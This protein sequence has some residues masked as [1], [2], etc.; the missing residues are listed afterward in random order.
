MA[1][2]QYNKDKLAKKLTLD[3]KKAQSN[4]SFSTQD[5]SKDKILPVTFQ[6]KWDNFWYHYK[7]HMLAAAFVVVLILSLIV[8]LVSRVKFDSTLT[9]LCEYDFQTSYDNFNMNIDEVLP[10]Y[11]EDG[12]SSLGINSILIADETNP[13]V[14]HSGEILMASQARI[15][16]TLTDG[17]SF[18]YM[19]D[20]NSYEQLQELGTVFLDLNKLGTSPN[21]INDKYY[22]KNTEISKLWEV[23][24]ITTDMFLCILDYSNIDKLNKLEKL[25]YNN[26]LDFMKNIIEYN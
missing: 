13:D 2:S 9:I 7:F 16:G 18:L 11:N 23:E 20:D 26:N 5:F 24:S 25:F 4:N 19:L 6:Q 22:L 15:M 1:D 8:S 3:V 12:Q 17:E 21:I 14:S 10:D